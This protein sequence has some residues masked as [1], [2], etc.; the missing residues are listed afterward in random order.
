[1][2]RVRAAVEVPGLASEA[3]ALW[4]DPQRWPAWVDGFGHL[5]KLE[6]EW[7]ALGARAVWDSRP[8]GRGR[9]VE[10]VTAYEARSGQTLAFE[11]EKTRGTQTVSFEPGP[12]GASVALELEYE[13]KDANLFTPLTDALFIRRAMRESLQRTVNRFARELRGDRELLG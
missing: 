1:V 12:D 10:R 4:Y 11:D 6:G 5:H 2:P 13:I 9:V 8:G 7:P 3:E